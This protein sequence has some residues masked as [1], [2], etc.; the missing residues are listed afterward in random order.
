MKKFKSLLGNWTSRLLCLVLFIFSAEML[1]AQD[2]ASA[3]EP[4]TAA[5]KITRK[6]VKNTF[7]SIW[8]IDNQTVM[9]PVKKTFEMDIMHRFG[10]WNNGYKDFFGL[11]ASSNIRLGFSYVPI[12]KLLIGVS[13]TKTNKTWEGYAK[14][15]II[16]QTK[17]RYPVSVSFYANAAVDSREKDNFRYFSDRLMYFNQVLIARK[18]TDKISLQVAPSVS[19]INVTDGYFSSPGKVSGIMKHDHFAVAVSGRYKLKESMSVMVN[20]DQPITKHPTDNPHPNISFGL[21]LGTG[22]H[23]FQFFAGNYYN[24]SPARN[25]FFNRNNYRDGQFLIGFNITRQWNY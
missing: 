16:E 21:E 1:K 12:N 5:K 7:E 25:N 9:V 6:P 4:A 10:T 22:G 14:Y 11:F 20:Y 18:F 17:G 13:I 24:I 8:I 2:S 23:S 19:H 3:E 15:A